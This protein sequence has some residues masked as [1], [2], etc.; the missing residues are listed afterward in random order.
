MNR[1]ELL[2]SSAERALKEIIGKKGGDTSKDV[3]DN[4]EYLT[5]K[6]TSYGEDF[7]YI[8]VLIKKLLCTYIDP[9]YRIEYVVTK[10]G[11]WCECEAKLYWSDSEQPAGIGFVRRYANQI[12]PFDSLSK[13]ERL[14]QLEANCRGASATRAIADAGVASHFWGDMSGFEIKGEM[15]EAEASAKMRAEAK[16]PEV[17]S[18][19]EKKA[20]KRE[21]AKSKAEATASEL[22]SAKEV[23]ETT[24]NDFASEEVVFA[25][26]CST[27]SFFDFLE[28]NE[29]TPDGNTEEVASEEI[30]LDD[31]LN[32]VSD[33]GTYK[34]QTLGNIYKMMPRNLVYLA[35]HSST[36]GKYARVIIATD[37]ALSKM[38][39]D[40]EEV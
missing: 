15:E 3:F 12:S 11:D 28:G 27:P 6:A 16:I 18:A 9:D 24:S 39:K 35:T 14:S 7:Y 13:E 38:L 21:K 4:L 10:G 5:D 33:M 29:E 22:P 20:E 1:K 30:G 2:S 25:E 37:E 40:A 8:P 34:G 26:D 32:A 19:V 31:A 36:V 17:K 23:F